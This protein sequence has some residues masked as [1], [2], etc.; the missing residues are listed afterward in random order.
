MLERTS[1][2]ESIFKTKSLL[3]GPETLYT[4]I[5]NRV[6]QICSNDG[7]ELTFI[8]LQQGQIC[9]LKFFKTKCFNINMKILVQLI[10]EMR[11]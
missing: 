5:G 4:E 1:S 11:T 10:I 3:N 8:F 7:L 2:G 6:H 9:F